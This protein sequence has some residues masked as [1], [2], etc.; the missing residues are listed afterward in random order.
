MKY[1]VLMSVY[2]KDKPQFLRLAMNSIFSQT[3]KTDDFVLVCDGPLD[4]ELNSVI[5]DMQNEHGEVLNVIRLDTNVGLGNALN[6]GLQMCKHDL[7]ARMDSDDISRPNRCEKQICVFMS[8]PDIGICSGI[9]EEFSNSID[10]I[11]VYN[12]PP[13]THDEIRSYAKRFNPFNHPCVMFKK[14]AVIS[15]GAYQDFYLLEDYF[16]WIRMLNKG[17]RAY[18]IQEPLL[19]MRAG[20]EMY[21]RRAG[22]K[23]IRSQ[24]KLFKYM[25]DNDFS[26][27]G[28][29][30]YSLFMRVGACVVPNC[31]REQ[32]IKLILRKKKLPK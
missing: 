16:L 10:N 19:W 26:D 8:K 3:V 18:N 15:V 1:S 24:I 13:E 21:K 31:V 27:L 20:K 22:L 14:S 6:I 7:V 30:L 32:G 12:V 29:C 9:V 11:D 2:Y 5:S 23:Y 25:Y 4:D 17:I 28:S